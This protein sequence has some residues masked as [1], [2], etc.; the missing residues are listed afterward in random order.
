[1]P[2]PDQA[3]MSLFSA[4]LEFHRAQQLNGV[5]YEAP[6]G[7]P[8][9]DTEKILFYAQ[10]NGVSP[11]VFKAALK[12]LLIVKEQTAR[13]PSSSSNIFGTYLE[14]IRGQSA[15][16]QILHLI[17]TGSRSITDIATELSFSPEEIVAAT[18]KA[19]QLGMVRLEKVGG[20][21][22]V[23]LTQPDSE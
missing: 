14:G 13:Q 20:Q 8:A 15:L 22:T 4:L 6:T 16:E 19:E 18:A 21:T 11:G 2:T 17:R 5:S 3:L 9:P 12:D 7:L 1:M 23:H 10:Q